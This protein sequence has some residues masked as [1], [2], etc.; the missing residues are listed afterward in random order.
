M[1]LNLFLF[2]QAVRPLGRK[3]VN[4]YLYLVLVL[5]TASE[6]CGVA[7]CNQPLLMQLLSSDEECLY[8]YRTEILIFFTSC[9]TKCM[10]HVNRVV[11][12]EVLP[13]LQ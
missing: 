7:E 3:S 5:E 12:I 9:T 8:S 10:S 6:D 2:Y 4:K 13:V 11:N 1:V